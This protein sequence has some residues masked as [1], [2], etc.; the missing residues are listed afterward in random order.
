LHN[1]AMTFPNEYSK[2]VFEVLCSFI[3]EET[4]KEEYKTKV[5]AE[6]E[7]SDKTQKAS[8][9]TLGLDTS[10]IRIDTTQI[11]LS[12]Q[13]TSLIVIQTIVDKLFREIVELD[14]TDKKTVQK[15]ILYRNHRANLSGA[16]LRGISLYNANLLGA[17]LRN[18]NLQGA[19][20]RKANLRG[21]GLYRVNLRDARLWE[22][23]LQGARLYD[24]DLQGANL[25][26]ADF[27]GVQGQSF[28]VDYR[29]AII[30]A[31]RTGFDLKTDLSGVRLYDDDEN[32]LTTEDAKKE[33]FIKHSIRDDV[34]NDLP[35]KEV[36][37]L[38]KVFKDWY[39]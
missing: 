7:S 12:K 33:W 37:K 28:W 24:A 13:V 25:N 6:I 38:F 29:K 34:V 8:S 26:G 4:R 36:L 10:Y 15:R 27:R 19:D 5:L 20:L 30:E 35:T 21:I 3:R 14:E 9:D 1:L 22:A 23:N 17:W 2:Q 32:E 39:L 16:F 11:T 31:V 18:V